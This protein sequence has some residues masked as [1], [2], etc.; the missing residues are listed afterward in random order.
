MD[1]SS[2][3]SPPS[4]SAG[5]PAGA[6]SPTPP[7]P[8]APRAARPGGLWQRRWFRWPVIAIA[9]YLVVCGLLAVALPLGLDR[10]A[11]PKASELIGRSITAERI[12]FN[13]FTLRLV[14]QGLRVA[15]PAATA[16]AADPAQAGQPEAA[17]PETGQPEA[18]QP[19]PG[20][21]PI[22]TGDTVRLAELDL[23]LSI[24]SVR[25][26]APVIEGLRLVGP[27]IRVARLADGRFDFQDI[28]DRIEAMPKSEPGTDEGEEADEGPAKFAFHNLEIVDGQIQFDDRQLAQQHD[29]TA[30]RVGIP[31][32]STLAADI[33]TEVL[34][35]LAA[36]VDGSPLSLSGDTL[37]FHETRRTH[38]DVKLDDLVIGKYL[39]LSPV[40]LGFTSPE[41]TLSI[42]LRV[43]FHRD[44]SGN[45]LTID[46]PVRIDGLALDAAGGDR[47]ASVRQV[48]ARLAN[49][50]PLISRFPVD[51]VS[52]DGL[53]VTVDRQA[54]GRLPIV[55]AFTPGKANA[56]DKAATGKPVSEG[57]ASGTPVAGKSTT[58][59]SE[60][61]STLTWSIAKTT[62]RDSR[63]TYTDRTTTP[64]V[65][66]DQHDITVDL[67]PVGNHQAE[68]APITVALRH[69]ENGRLD[70]KGQLDLAKSRAGGQIDVALPGIAD[71]LPFV[72]DQLAAKL[73]TGSIT[74]GSAFESQWGG[75]LGLTLR[76]GTAA[77]EAVHLALPD[78]KAKEPAVR[79][80]RVAVEALGL[81][82]AERRLTIGRAL[83]AKADLRVLRDAR[84]QLNLSRISASGQQ[85]AAEAATGPKARRAAGRAP[86]H[87]AAA[88]SVKAGPKEGSAAGGQ[89]KAGPA[90]V[91]EVARVDLDDNRVE[92][93]D[94]ATPTAVNLPISRLSGSIANVGTQ[95]DRPANADLRMTVGRNGQVTAK[96]QAVVEPLSLDMNLQWRNLALAVIDPYLAEAIGVELRRAD[97]T[98][99]GR[100]RYG[101]DRARFAGRLA[102]TG[103]DA[104]ERRT[105]DELLRWKVLNINGIDADVLTAA[106]KG[107]RRGPP[108][109]VSIGEIALSD[110]FARAELSADGRLNISD[111]LK[112]AGDDK[113]GPGQ[114][115][116]GQSGSAAK[117]EGPP[118]QIRIGGITLKDGAANFT[119]NFV[120]PNYSADLSGLSGTIS[121]MAS[122]GSE[123]ADVDI[124]GIVNGDAPIEIGGKLNPLG[125]TLYTDV[126]ASAKGIDL[127]T[128]S[129]Y[130]G[131]YAG[132]TIEKGKLSLDVH[133]QI[134]N[135]KLQATNRIF[136]DQLT[137]G[138]KV[139]SPDATNLPVQFAIG[140]LKNNRGEIDLNLPISGSLDDPQFSFGGIIWNAFVNLITRVVTSPFTA[141]A[142]AFGGGEELSFVSFEPGTAVLTSESRDRL[143]TISK[144]L[145]DRPALKLEITGRMDPKAEAEAFGKARLEQRL[146]ALRGG[147]EDDDARIDLQDAPP[148]KP[149]AG[150]KSAG[151]AAGAS[152]PRQ[153]GSA[154]SVGAG[155]GG[156]AGS[157]AGA[158]ASGQKPGVPPMSPAQREGLVKRLAQMLK[159]PLTG[160]AAAR[161]AADAKAADPKAADPTTSGGQGAQPRGAEASGG[162]SLEARVAAALAADPDAQRS[163]AIRRAQVPRNWLVGQGKIDAERIFLL[164]PKVGAGAGAGGKTSE[165]VDRPAAAGAG[166][167]DG[168]GAATSVASGE[169]AGAAKASAGAGGGKCTRNCAEFS[170]R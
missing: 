151:D 39:T 160:P 105:G 162:S 69:N 73:E 96:G 74:F 59:R 84:G 104:A 124:D 48:E 88:A 58:T 159:V 168:P 51:S 134:E 7:K 115:S 62:V 4:P 161:G 44:D 18:G 43:G 121:A 101:K 116:K 82:L 111:L 37:P 56:S 90:W 150:D 81:S 127:P 147:R 148:A 31:F 15:G 166:E 79:L 34:P 100:L 78:D 21:A 75:D 94:R 66:L 41:G 122:E 128:F 65:K 165:A 46:G 60:P 106:G 95:L 85:A 143:A 64:A 135:D 13:P 14:A 5:S 145:T 108:D 114:A 87:G 40:P 68:P 67:G 1:P 152:K 167:A 61:R 103:L 117:A 10:Y 49:V 22:G 47:L 163:L 142:S 144:A 16:V 71:Y 136:L 146:Q 70:W 158:E 93:Q 83:L 17:K 112:S 141:L 131:K 119:D 28:V 24:L 107:P 137:F 6:R 54:D 97:A 23:N 170:L 8:K 109:R 33:T 27:E 32:I 63:I 91:V 133:Y 12:R 76:D 120:K 86:G 139:D 110:F 11:L 126:T 129:P 169:G 125:P 123:P 38:L 153:A 155:P 36:V 42:D 3:S 164:A 130:S 19:R 26:L 140:L 156:G 154:S 92:W 72:A 118:M 113:A 45:H 9:V 25:Y 80:G 102:V 30:L 138:E 77:V 52:V 53:D 50:E 20:G 99:N 35:A 57:S 98:G 132:Y 149:G 2:P 89:E 157:G 55:E 29:V